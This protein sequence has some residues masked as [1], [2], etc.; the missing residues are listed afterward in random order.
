MHQ[1]KLSYKQ[2]SAKKAINNKVS[3]LFPYRQKIKNAGYYIAHK[4]GKA[5]SSLRI[6][7]APSCQIP[8]S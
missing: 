3:L 8:F 2:F 6:M 5:L 4:G 1:R 7:T